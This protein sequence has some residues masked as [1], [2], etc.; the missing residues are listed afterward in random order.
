MQALFS[1]Y[2]WIVPLVGIGVVAYRFLG[3]R[4]LLAVV[5]LGGLGGVYTKGKRD[6]RANHERE[7]AERDAKAKGIRRDVEDSIK[8]R[9]LSDK[10]DDLSKWMRDR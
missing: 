2:W 4:G 6:E 7:Q 5:T 9:S 1:D 10:R 8:E 3:W